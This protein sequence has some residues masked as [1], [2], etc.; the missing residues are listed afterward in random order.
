MNESPDDISV[1]SIGA[2]DFLAALAALRCGKA[3][4]FPTDTVYGI[5]VAVLRGATPESIYSIKGRDSDKAIPWLVGSALALEDYAVDVPEYAYELARRFWPGALT[6]I[7][8]ASAAVPATFRAQDGT[9]AL[10]VP[11]NPIACALIEQ[12]G[13]PIATSSA[14][15]QGNQPATSIESL[16]S[17]LLGADIPVVDGGSTPGPVPSTIVSCL[18]E[19]PEILREGVLSE[20]EII[21][22]IS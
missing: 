21:N 8:K 6:L 1:T 12:L 9:I 14:N 10:R 15:L 16:D 17:G 5:G 18:G 11:D 3:A 13:V 22:V 20:H 7:V 19:R 2:P 4:I